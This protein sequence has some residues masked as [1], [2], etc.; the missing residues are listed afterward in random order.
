MGETQSSASRVILTP[1]LVG[2]SLIDPSCLRIL[3]QWRDGGLVPVVS[4]GLLR[5]YLRLLSGLGLP[6]LQLRRWAWWFTSPE[7][8]CFVDRADPLLQTLPELCGLLAT[9]A[10][11]KWIIHSGRLS[12]RPEEAAPEQGH[13]WISAVDYLANRAK[14]PGEVRKF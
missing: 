5:R 2:G 6:R 7:K 8:S 10:G 3:E 14:G 13:P 4:P 9:E 1:C 12:F 11:L